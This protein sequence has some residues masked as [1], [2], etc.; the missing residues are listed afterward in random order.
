[1]NDFAWQFSESLAGVVDKA[2]AGVVRINGRRRR[3]S[4]GVIWSSGVVVTT[5]HVLE[6]E[7]DIAIGFP[8]GTTSTASVVGRDP[9]T[10][11]AAL[12]VAG[13]TPEPTEW[14]DAGEVKAGHLVM[15]LSRPGRQ[16]RTSLGL[17]GA[18]GESWRTPMGG[19]IDTEIQ[20]DL[21]IHTGFSGSALVDMRGRVIGVNTA[22]IYRATASVIP[23]V[24]VR[25]VVDALLAHGQVRRGYLG[26]GTQPVRLPRELAER[27]GQPSG[28]LIVSVQPGSPA[29]QAGLVLGDAILSFEGTPLRHPGE[30]LPLLEEER[31]GKEATLNILRAGEVRDV[32]VTI[33]A[34]NG[35]ET[36]E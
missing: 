27:L 32:R 21:G 13:P 1:M 35:K 5:H 34:R 16:I 7:E 31:I 29:D 15:S 26:I 33:G 23:T 10:D 24:T 18:V 17:V 19:R 2:A 11:L 8:D 9:S 36:A 22:G 28:L 14:G 4:S 12:R 20:T 6:W 3:P 25:R 30:L